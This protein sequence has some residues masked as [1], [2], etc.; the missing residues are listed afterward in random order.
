MTRKKLEA[1]VDRI[2]LKKARGEKLS[3][4]EQRIL[5]YSYYAAGCSACYAAVGVRDSTERQVIGS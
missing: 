4:Q 3:E 1:E 2:L 5:A